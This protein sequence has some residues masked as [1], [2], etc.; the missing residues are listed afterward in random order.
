MFNRIGEVVFASE[1][2]KIAWDGRYRGEV[3]PAGVY[4]YVLSLQWLNGA[5]DVNKTGTVQLMR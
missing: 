1:D 3:L 2:D 4:T 5:A